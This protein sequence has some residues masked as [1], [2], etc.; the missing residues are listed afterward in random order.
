MKRIT[1]TLLLLGSFIILT[2]SCGRSIVTAKTATPEN[3]RN[4]QTAWLDQ[5]VCKPPCWQN[6]TPGVT[7]RDEAV[8]ILENTPGVAITY[9]KKSGLSWN[10]G[11]KAEGGNIIVSEDGIVSGVW[12]GSTNE[13]LYLKKVTAA[14]SF[15]KY[16]KP[17]DCRVG[18]CETVLIYPDLGML[19][20]V[21]VKDAR[22]DDEIPQIEILSETIVYRVYF[23]EQGM[24]N[25]QK[26]LVF[27][28]YDL[29]LEWKGYGEYP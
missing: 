22:G 19:L 10:F 23:I 21:F 6:I 3:S 15:P 25:F 9:N 4:W 1:N 14:Y 18:M 28:D 12:L 27:Q 11:T 17:Y 2:A 8:L 5:P 7:T 20:S 24:E 13:N 29:L 16:V 26:I